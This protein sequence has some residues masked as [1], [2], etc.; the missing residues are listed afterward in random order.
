MTNKVLLIGINY[1]GT[2][3]E[4]YGCINDVKNM[5]KYLYNNYNINDIKILTDD[6]KIKPTKKNMIK[7]LQWLINDVKYG[8]NLFFHYSGHGSHIHDIEGDEDNGRD[9]T[10]CPLDYKKNG[11]IIDDWLR[12]NI[13]NKI[14]EGV[15]LFCIFDCCHSESLMDLHYTYNI[16]RKYY[17]TKKH[18]Q[19]KK[20]SGQVIT[21]SGCL[22]EEFSYDAIFKINDKE[23]F[24]ARGA[25]TH[26]L[27][28]LLNKNKNI[29]YKDLIRNLQINLRKDGFNQKPKLCSGRYIKLNETNIS[30]LD[31]NNNSKHLKNKKYRHKIEDID[32]CVL[33]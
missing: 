8:D 10:L 12:E 22:D 23:E 3:S 9:E 11:L 18:K 31:C 5:R 33:F 15:K 25:M 1:R 21:I 29:N 17:N 32:K 14:P 27:L 28:K 30:F 26:H 20:P 2:K 4:L 19:Y 6:T 7:A 13:V 16:C 24:E